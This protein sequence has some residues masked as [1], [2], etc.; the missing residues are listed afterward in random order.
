VRIARRQFLLLLLLLYYAL[1][2]LSE[3]PAQIS[4][5]KKFPSKIENTESFFEKFLKT[6]RARKKGQYETTVDWQKRIKKDFD[7]SKTLYFKRPDKM[8]GVTYDADSQTISAEYGFQWDKRESYEQKLFM[9]DV[10]MLGKETARVMGGNEYDVVC[11]YCLFIRDIIKLQ[12]YYT[13]SNVNGY[14]NEKL[15]ISFPLPLPKA[16]K[17]GDNVALI[18]GAR[19]L[20]YEA[21]SEEYGFSP[22]A[23][24]ISC[25]L[26]S[27][28]LIDK[29]TEE[30]LWHRDF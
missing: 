26:V 28:T 11:E 27:L 15:V 13:E 4:W 9:V 23:D 14:K 24:V 29:K 17:V 30:V 1:F 6:A 25:D 7:A 19:G 5:G 21:S 18:I 10:Q 8:M 2:A 16:K 12:P 3:S 20:S 22:I